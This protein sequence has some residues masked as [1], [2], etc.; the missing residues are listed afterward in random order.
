MKSQVVEP[1]LYKIITKSNLHGYLLSGLFV[2]EVMA[3]EAYGPP[4]D[5]S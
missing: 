3:N 1:E 2:I 5:S 4:D